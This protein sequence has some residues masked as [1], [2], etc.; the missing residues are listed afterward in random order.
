MN[1]HVTKDGREFIIRQPTEKDAADI[2]NYSKILFA[3]TDQVLT[4]VEEYTIT[5]E[6]EKTWINS[7]N[8]N[9]NANLLVAELNSQIIGLLFFIPNAKKKNSH[10]GE[11][12]VNVHPNFQ[13][14]G[15]GRL[16]VETLLNWAKDNPQIEKVFLSVFHTNRHAIKLYKHLGFIE[17]G[18]HIKAIKQLTGEYVDVIQMYI[19]TK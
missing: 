19:E 3:S 13:G 2:I 1:T 16:L 11:F 18:R 4:T 5:V 9:P 15:I 6:N 12:G 17:E 8:Q 7:F 14:I 10:T